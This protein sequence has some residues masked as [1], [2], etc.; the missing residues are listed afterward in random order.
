MFK[1]D[2]D[3]ISIKKRKKG[4]KESG[5][6]WREE[7]A[8][9]YNSSTGYISK[10]ANIN[11][12][13]TNLFDKLNSG[14]FEFSDANKILESKKLNMEFYNDL[15]EKII[16][17]S[18]F[19]K[20]KKYISGDNEIYNLVKSKTLSFEKA[21]K[22]LEIQNYEFGIY[23]EFIYG[24]RTFDEIDIMY[25]QLK[26]KSIFSEKIVTDEDFEIE[27]NSVS[28]SDTSEI[29]SNINTTNE[30]QTSGNT[31]NDNQNLVIS[32][33]VRTR[34][35]SLAALKHKSVDELLLELLDSYQNN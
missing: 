31:F 30:E 15:V 6:D 34:I 8:K 1:K 26:E 9:F 28:T 14:M 23:E 4:S 5:Y 12:C 7:A 2:G 17:V 21:D 10:A 35:I 29:A 33:N 18:D 19:G 22:L 20:Y 32:N 16:P 11:K 24:E 27:D 3:I 13:D 25:K